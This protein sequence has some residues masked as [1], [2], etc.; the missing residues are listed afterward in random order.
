MVIRKRYVPGDYLVICDRTGMVRYRSECEYE[1]N[2]LL[3]W[4][5]SWEPR[6]PQDFVHGVA[7]DQSVPDARS[8]IASTIGQTTVKVTAAAGATTID[9]T[10]VAN[11]GDDDGIGIVLDDG[12]THWTFSDGTPAGD[13]VTLG[14]YLPGAATALNVVYLPEVT[15]HTEATYITGDDL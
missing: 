2:G 15:D 13:T 5:K 9:L 4:E 10:S 11:I 14:S 12:T 7:D 6:H 3:V 8:D 1:W